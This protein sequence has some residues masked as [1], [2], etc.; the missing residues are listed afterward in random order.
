MRPQIGTPP[1]PVALSPHNCTIDGVH[2][3]GRYFMLW[4]LGIP[5]PV[6]AMIYMFGGLN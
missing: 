5:L 1:H 2:S 6:L 4:M 3:M